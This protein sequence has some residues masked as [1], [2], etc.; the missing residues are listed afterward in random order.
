M[1]NALASEWYLLRAR[2]VPLVVGIVWAVMVA[3]FAVLVPYVVYLALPASSGQDT[4][5]I[6]DG[7]LL[8]SSATAVLGSYPM[9]GG[10]VMLIFGIL[11]AGPEYRWGTWTARFTQG[12]TR[13]QVVL[14]KAVVAALVA[15]AM[16]VGA[17]VLATLASAGVTA[18]EGRALTLPPLTQTLGALAGSALIAAVWT[19]V[20]L[21][22]S[23]VLRGTTLA[24][25]VGLVWSLALENVVSGLAQVVSALEPVRH[26]LLG[27]ASGSL[28]SGLGAPAQDAG[29]TPGVV[30]V[31]S[32]P[33]ALLVMAAYAAVA[34]LAATLLARRRD[35]A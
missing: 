21:G 32:T 13:T 35:I 5:A 2:R 27:V 29:G 33:T 17:H 14:A 26:A 3:V 16:T 31:L 1:T 19:V 24:L 15:A 10:A 22:L 34:L 20:G 7:V 9:F 6:L 12:P 23:I 18:V 25:I 28:V 11:V 8:E 4:G 30:S